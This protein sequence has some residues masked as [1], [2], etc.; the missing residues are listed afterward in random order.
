ME[1]LIKRCP[2]NTGTGQSGSGSHMQA[3]SSSTSSLI[4]G[5]FRSAA[6]SAS[7]WFNP[8][9]RLTSGRPA[10]KMF[11]PTQQRPAESQMSEAAMRARQSPALSL[12]NRLDGLVLQLEGTREFFAEWPQQLCQRIRARA[13]QGGPTG[14]ESP[15]HSMLTRRTNSTS[16]TTTECW[17]G[18]DFSG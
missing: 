13:N 5:L 9:Q 16:A 12:F 1:Q 17:N 2:R 10:G 6:D 15:H 14:N 11:P 8:Q 7:D 18:R 4:S 3:G